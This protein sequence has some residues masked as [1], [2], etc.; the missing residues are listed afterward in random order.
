MEFYPFFHFLSAANRIRKSFLAS[1]ESMSMNSRRSNSLARSFF[2]NTGKEP[3]FLP[4]PGRL[5]PWLLVF[6]LCLPHLCGDFFT[7]RRA[8]LRRTKI[9]TDHHLM[10]SQFTPQLFQDCFTLLH[11]ATFREIHATVLEPLP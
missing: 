10:E 8:S 4:A 1:P 2:R 7:L 5:P 6:T 11:S 3:G 9:H